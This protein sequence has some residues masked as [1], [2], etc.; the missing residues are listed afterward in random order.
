MKAF[1]ALGITLAT[2]IVIG[3]FVVAGKAPVANTVSAAA[4]FSLT[5]RL[6]KTSTDT[7]KTK[8]ANPIIKSVVKTVINTFYEQADDDMKESYESMTDDD[9]DKLAEII[10]RNVTLKTIPQLKSYASEDDPDAL[11]KYAKDNLP[12]ED[13]EELLAL[14]EKY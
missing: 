8:T 5:S 7:K 4:K 14:L 10:A 9:K 12:K 6:S 13:Y 11:L 1:K 3:G 2:I